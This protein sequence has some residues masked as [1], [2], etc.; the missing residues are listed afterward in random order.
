MMEIRKF[1]AIFL[2]I[3]LIT[4]AA[5]QEINLQ[6]V[7]ALDTL[8]IASEASSKE[9]LSPIDTLH[10]IDSS[11]VPDSGKNLPKDI[12]SET[13]D[14]LGGEQFFL[15]ASMGDRGVSVT[16]NTYIQSSD[17]R[18]LLPSPEFQPDTA[19]N[20]QTDS[21]L[22]P[23]YKMGKTEKRILLITGAVLVAGGLVFLLVKSI[24][25][26]EKATENAGFPEPPRPPEY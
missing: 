20:S 16:S 15:Q 19:D 5:G 13:D 12:K 24:G 10:N 22:A 3:N 4:I 17:T 26:G 7:D 6:T 14:R 2:I 1:I 21:S 23:T 18:K 8:D 11:V 9:E 25:K